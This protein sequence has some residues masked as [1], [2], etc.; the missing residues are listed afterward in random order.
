[1]STAK[2][3][4]K[5]KDKKAQSGSSGKL[6]FIRVGPQIRDK[7][8]LTHVLGN[9][10]RTELL[11]KQRHIYGLR[12]SACRNPIKIFNSLSDVTLGNVGLQTTYKYSQTIITAK[13]HQILEQ[14]T[15]SFLSPLTLSG[16][17]KSLFLSVSF[18]ISS[19]LTL[20]RLSLHHLFTTKPLPLSCPVFVSLLICS[21]FLSPGK[22]F[23]PKKAAEIPEH[24]QV[25]LEPELEE[26]L[27]NATDA[28]MCDI[29]G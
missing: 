10:I 12:L 2:R 4:K 28:E 25:M 24:E 11:P 22:T 14:Q 8:S 16:F 6:E 3:K 7:P 27:K 9:M 23:V 5:K 17:F 21:L 29:A 15:K 18:C 1:M 20:S 19:Y 26:A 13:L